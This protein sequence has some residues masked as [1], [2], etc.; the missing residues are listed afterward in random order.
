MKPLD[1]FLAGAEETSIKRLSPEEIDHAF[2][3]RITRLVRNDAT[4]KIDSI[5]FEVPPEFIGHRVDIRF[6][7]ASPSNLILYRDDRPITPLKPVDA[8]DNA[9]FHAERIELAYSKIDSTEDD[10]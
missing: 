5:F 6:P 9:R 7:V 4:V 1:R 3:G 2:M 10:S 8:A